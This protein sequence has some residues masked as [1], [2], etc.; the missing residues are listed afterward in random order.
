MKHLP[1]ISKAIAVTSL[2]GTFA[3]SQASTKI[4]NIQVS[5]DVPQNQVTRLQQDITL[6]KSMNFSQPDPELLSLMEI[7]DSS[8][9]TLLAWMQA[10]IHF[11]IDENFDLTKNIVIA[12]SSYNYP[13]SIIPTMETPPKNPTD[14]D[15]QSGPVVTVMLNIGGAVYL[16]G[17]EQGSLLEMKIPG[18]GKEKMTSPRVGVL[19]VGQ[20]LFAQLFKDPSLKP[21]SKPYVA[22]RLAT[23]FHE[24][25][26]SDGN[27]ASLGFLHAVCATGTYAGYSACDRNLNGPYQVETAFLKSM[28]Q[29]CTDCSEG[30][31]NAMLALAADA[32]SRQIK[33][34]ADPN[35]DP[36]SQVA[37]LQQELDL[38]QLM[39]KL[40]LPQTLPACSD[41][42]AL[43]KQIADLQTQAPSQGIPSTN[44]DPTPEGV[45]QQ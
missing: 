43:Q 2:L 34:T 15:T 42:P 14:G 38:C 16:M 9:G 10:R 31:K 36:S 4:E 45:F 20:G 25:R 40:H 6:L 26:H 12:K 35:S 1:M 32:A 39:Q 19:K 3:Q 44:W 27:G 37:A 21:D 13:N 18:V 17:K 22:L 11:I 5:Q 8:P 23:L 7:K 33:F 29:S 28:I 24:A 41:I 30:D